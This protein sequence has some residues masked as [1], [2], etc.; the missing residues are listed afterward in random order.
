MRKSKLIICI[1][2]VLLMTSIYVYT[3]A[4]TELAFEINYDGVVTKGEEK[5]VKIV[6]AGTNATAYTNVR[7]NVTITGPATPKLIATDSAGQSID[8]ATIG[9]WGPE[10][11]FPVQGTFQNTTPVKAT[12]P[13]SGDYTIK[14][15]LVDLQ[16]ASTVLATKTEAITVLSSDVTN[17]IQ[18]TIDNTMQNVQEL[19][20]TGTSVVEYGLYFI[21]GA[22][23]LYCVYIINKKKINT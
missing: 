14:L 4:Q 6:L 8:I 22:L 23:I 2:L 12:F 21:V 1:I 10:T 15:D 16:N 3:Y 5:D 18:N 9:Y 7:V 11:G 19:P 20:K 13:E 17:T